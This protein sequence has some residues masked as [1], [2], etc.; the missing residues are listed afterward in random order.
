MILDLK[1]SVSILSEKHLGI[2]LFDG[3]DFTF[4]IVK[5][6]RLLGVIFYTLLHLTYVSLIKLFY[7]E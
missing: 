2:Y 7:S 3:K 1:N 6:T 5:I 4:L